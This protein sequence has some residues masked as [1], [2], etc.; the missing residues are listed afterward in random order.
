MNG[1]GHQLLACSA[2][3]KDQDIGRS[4]RHLFDGRIHL[5]H[6]TTLAYHVSETDRLPHLF[7]K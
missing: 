1:P 6:L 5:E 7:E 4:I 3:T 2:F